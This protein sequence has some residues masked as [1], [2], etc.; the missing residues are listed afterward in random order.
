LGA[1]AS[2]ANYADSQKNSESEFLHL[3]KD[4]LRSLGF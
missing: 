1:A 2:K 4:Y 3:D